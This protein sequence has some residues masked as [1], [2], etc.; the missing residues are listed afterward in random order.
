MIGGP[1][2]V[3]VYIVRYPG[4]GSARAEA[5]GN[6]MFAALYA[7]LAALA[8]RS[9]GI[10]VRFRT[11]R[12]PG[13]VPVPVPFGRAQHT[14]VF[15]LA[16]DRLVADPAWC[17]Y[18]GGLAS[19]AGRTD[20]VVPVAITDVENLPPGLDQNQAIRLAEVPEAEQETVLLN[21]VMHD[22]CILLDPDAQKVKVFLSYA[23]RDGRPIM[24]AV[25]NHLRFVAGL[26]DFFD[27]ADVPDGTRFADFLKERA[28]SLHALL[29]IQT[30]TY[31]SREWCRLEVLEA[32]RRH[33]PI[34]VL[35]AVNVSET[36]SFPYIG[37]TPVVRWCGDETSLRRVV[38]ALLGEVLWRRYFPRRVE[39]L[40]EEYNLDRGLQVFAHP[41]ELVTML[42]YRAEMTAEGAAIGEYL[43][44]D[45]PLG[46]EELQVLAQLDPDI[47]PVTPIILQAREMRSS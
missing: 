27:T 34:V 7:D 11:S 1:P 40:C 31:A 43:Y 47:A 35:S 6:S 3:I 12:L 2:V 37:N 19:S 30:D 20:L 26:D 44:P 22:L 14:A 41:P 42:T 32:K 18:V 16:D 10:E 33:V 45:P 4:P 36:R 5:L 9:L 21:R 46:T 17:S 38:R 13:T 28:G 15:V 25:S 8:S 39:A 24:E 29:A 23:R